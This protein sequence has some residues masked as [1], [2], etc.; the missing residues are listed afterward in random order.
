MQAIILVFASVLLAL[1]PARIEAQCDQCKGDFNGSG[2][3]TIDEI[4]TA[5]NNALSGCPLPGPRLLDNGDG[6]VT[7]TKTGLLWE[8]KSD[9]GSVHDQDNTYTWSTGSPAYNPDGTAFTSFLATLNSAPC[10]AK[11]CDW[12]LPTM[13]ELQ[14]LVAYERWAPAIDPV[15]NAACDPDCTVL[16]CSCT[17]LDDFYWSST[18]MAEIPS[19]DA[20]NVGFNQGVVNLYPKT[21]GSL[22]G[23]S[24]ARAVRGGL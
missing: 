14:S 4:L 20:W 7:D 15:F 8:K 12:R 3:V 19:V 22:P 21:F 1:W 17:S 9:D 6:T 11:H 2:N 5:V 18:P 23:G 13:T 10:F 24:Y 16:T